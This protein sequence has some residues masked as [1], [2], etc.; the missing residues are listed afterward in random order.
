[1]DVDK[2]VQ[3]SGLSPAADKKTAGPIEKE[4]FKNS[5]CFIFKIRLFIQMTSNLFN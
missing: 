1:M 4:T 5:K 3:G 2:K